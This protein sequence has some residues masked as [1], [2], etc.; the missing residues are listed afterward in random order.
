MQSSTRSVAVACFFS[1]PVSLNPM[2][3][4]STIDVH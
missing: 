3:S 2:T 1:Y 4:G